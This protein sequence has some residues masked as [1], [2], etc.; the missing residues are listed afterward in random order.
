MDGVRLGIGLTILGVGITLVLGLPP[1][2]WSDMP[3]GL[4]HIGVGFGL[5]LIV[6]GL[7]IT[8]SSFPR[9]NSVGTWGPWVLI[10]GGPILGLAWL[11]LG[12]SSKPYAPPA[13][14]AL[15]HNWPDPVDRTNLR[16]IFRNIS[17][18]LNKEVSPIQL[19]VH[20][21]IDNVRRNIGTPAANTLIDE[22]AGF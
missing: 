1:N 10:V 13:R 4:V 19:R 9:H 7:A 16:A 5:V 22:L 17:E 11:Y 6:I 8:V 2:W 14:P 12:A 21:D 15:L 18:I 20:H 3:P